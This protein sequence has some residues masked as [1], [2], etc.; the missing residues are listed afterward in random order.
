MMR[1]EYL[2]A[3]DLE[4]PDK[5]VEAAP[6]LAKLHEK[7][8]VPATFF[9][10]GKVLEAKGKELVSIL[11]DSPLFDLQSHTYSHR[12]L[13]D[14]LMHGL[15]IS[16]ED[17]RTEI[18]LG[19]KLV[20]DVFERPCIGVRSGC[21]FFRGFQG[22][23]DRLTVIASCGVGFLSTDLRGPADSIPGGLGQAYW[24]DEEGFPDLLEMP[25]H[26]WHD[27]VLKEGWGIG[28]ILA[29]PRY[30]T[31]GIPNRPVRTPEEE[32]EVQG[33]WIGEAINCDLDY[34]SLVYHPHSVYRLSSE[35]KTIE[36]LLQHVLALGMTTTTYSAL[37]ERYAAN[38]KG[39]PGRDA[40]PWERQQE[41]GPLVV[42]GSQVGSLR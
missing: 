38:P 40:W 16:L 9:V 20:E 28:L 42:G 39:V 2:F 7:Y 21:G 15:G 17:L 41:T 11:G 26:G 6:V 8:E 33:T 18:E 37:Y 13:R 3:Y 29:W 12:L 34:V 19:K 25:G 4:S 24:Y 1:T 14:N 30:M 23:R 35:C 32:L 5:C 31:W 27:N 36:L 10:V 22:Q